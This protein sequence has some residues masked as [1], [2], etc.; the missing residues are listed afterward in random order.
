MGGVPGKVVVPATLYYL[1]NNLPT[2]LRSS[3]PAEEL[4][5]GGEGVRTVCAG[6]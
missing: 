6:D 1:R 5:G 3:H 2:G 4:D